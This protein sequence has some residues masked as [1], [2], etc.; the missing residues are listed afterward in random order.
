MKAFAGASDET[1]GLALVAAMEAS[2]SLASTPPDTL[3]DTFAKFPEPVHTAL[4]AARAKS[5]PPDQAARLAELESSLPP[6][7]VERGLIVFQSAKAACSTC[8]PV[9]YKGGNLGPDL[10][11]VG[12]IR[13]RRDLIESLVFPS[14]SFVRS[15][16]PVQITRTDDTVAYGI[17]VNQNTDTLTLATGATTPPARVPRHDIKNLTPGQFSLMPQG[18]DQSLTPQELA[19]VIAYLQSRR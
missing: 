9:G 8:H 14:A 3:R 18:I 1:A 7:D 6:G 12:A 17:V 19:D 10:S 13:T 4:A 11:K 16:E 2:H 5:E 15:Y